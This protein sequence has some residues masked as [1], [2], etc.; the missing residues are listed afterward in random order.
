MSVRP[1]I[2]SVIEQVAKEHERSLVPLTDDL[3][4]FDTGLDSL[5]LAVIVVRLEEE[6]KIDPFTD[7]SDAKFPV[8]LGD[9]IAAYE[10]AVKLL[11]PKA[12]PKTD[13]KVDP[14]VDPKAS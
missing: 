5:A 6:L 1:K 10:N 11:E 3:D 4:L 12:D 9:F 7:S 2:I 8:T 13:P 14:K